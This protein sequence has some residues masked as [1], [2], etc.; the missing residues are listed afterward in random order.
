MAFPGA[1]APQQPMAADADGEGAE[2]ATITI[3]DNGDGTYSIEQG[4]AQDDAAEP[5]PGPDAGPE[6]EQPPVTVQSVAEVCHVITQMLAK[7]GDPKAAWQA[8]A[9]KRG[10]SGMP[11]PAAP[12]GPPMSM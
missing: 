5:A 8:E 7:T 2:P 1:P 3:T 4:D 6:S 9:S 12:A 10:P 11:A